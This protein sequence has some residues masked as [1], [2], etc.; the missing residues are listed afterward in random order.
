[1]VTDALILVV[2]L[3]NRNLGT[4]GLRGFGQTGT[5]RGSTVDQSTSQ[6]HGL[7]GIGRW[8]CSV[9]RRPRMSPRQEGGR[10]LLSNKTAG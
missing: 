4:G 1:V 7:F 6:I 9:N 2:E 5:V 3:G 10:S 8:S